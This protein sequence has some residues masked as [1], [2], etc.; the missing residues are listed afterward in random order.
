MKDELAFAFILQLN[1]S[2]Q[3]LRVLASSPLSSEMFDV[4]Y[5]GHNRNCLVRYNHGQKCQ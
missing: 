3:A 1:L 4:S 5:S 2:C